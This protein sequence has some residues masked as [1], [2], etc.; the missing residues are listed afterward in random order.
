MTYNS[1]YEVFDMLADV[2]IARQ[3]EWREQAACRGA[4]A[5]GDGPFFSNGTREGATEAAK[6]FCARCPVSNECHAD[7]E[8]M[9]S[10]QRKHGVWF[11]L[12]PEERKQL[13]TSGEG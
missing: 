3:A 5:N 10:S 13:L 6:A 7:W 12:S 1:V 11:G 4:N 8:R 2:M 9:P